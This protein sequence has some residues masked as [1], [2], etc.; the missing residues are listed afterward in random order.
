MHGVSPDPSQGTGEGGEL[1]HTLSKETLGSPD[2]SELGSPRCTPPHF[3]LFNM[4]VSYKRMALFLEPVADAVELTRFLLRCVCVLACGLVEHHIIYLLLALSSNGRKPESYRSIQC[5]LLFFIPQ[6]EDAR[7][8]SA[9]LC[10]PQCL[11]L[12]C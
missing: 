2:A 8:L 1:V 12:H 11:L 10:I 5:H 7:V 4:V 9:C 6:L 3:D